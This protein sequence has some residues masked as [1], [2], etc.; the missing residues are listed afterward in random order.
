MYALYFTYRANVDLY[1]SQSSAVRAELEFD[2][3]RVTGS[4]SY[5][6][7]RPLQL[8]SLPTTCNH[9]ARSP[10]PLLMDVGLIDNAPRKYRNTDPSHIL[11]SPRQRDVGG[12]TTLDG[13]VRP[14]PVNNDLVNMLF[15]F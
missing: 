4:S 15:H 8:N 10:S 12:S 3:N 1:Q 11:P 13:G 2:I 6:H 14:S 5:H 7:L 9:P